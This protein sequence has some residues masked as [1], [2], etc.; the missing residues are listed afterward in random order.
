VPPLVLKNL[1]RIRESKFLTQEQLADKAGM[2]RSAIARLETGGSARLG[3]APKLA[4]ALGV[5]PRELVETEGE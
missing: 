1:K 3:T 5:E 2:S 4:K